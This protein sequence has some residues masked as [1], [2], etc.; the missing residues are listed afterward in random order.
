MRKSRRPP[1]ESEDEAD[2]RL[3]RELT[4]DVGA[5][6]SVEEQARS[7]GK[8]RR[9][10][11]EQRLIGCPIW[12]LQSVLPSLKSAQE[13]VV[14]LYIWRRH[15][16]IG[17]RTF[18]LSNGELSALGVT[19]WTKYRALTKLERGGLITVQR[20]GKAAATVTTYL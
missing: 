17:R 13:V 9:S 4:A 7:P 6:E 20:N 16:V 12:W 10:K 8:S 19:R 1:P 14:A 15:I 5:D 2:E 3:L 11:F 18:T